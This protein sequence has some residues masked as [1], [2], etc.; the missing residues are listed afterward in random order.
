M[1]PHD[2]AIPLGVRLDELILGKGSD[3]FWIPKPTNSEQME[4]TL[5]L[6]QSLRR[7]ERAFG[8]ESTIQQLTLLRAAAATIGRKNAAT[9]RIHEARR[10]INAEAAAARNAGN[11]AEAKAI[12]SRPTP[13][14]PQREADEREVGDVERS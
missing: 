13:D 6:A 5:E 10:E 12:E 2:D 9:R 1:T 11:E 8:L 3:I 4:A 7:Y 14:Y